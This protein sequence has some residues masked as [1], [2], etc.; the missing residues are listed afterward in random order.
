MARRPHLPPELL[1]C[2]SRPSPPFLA[3]HVRLPHSPCL[4]RPSVS[5]SLF[6][7]GQK[8]SDQ[9]LSLP[10]SLLSLSQLDLRAPFTFTPLASLRPRGVPQHR[11]IPLLS[12]S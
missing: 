8:T 12:A 3:H 10:P 9:T 7:R 5:P 4:S 1:P 2:S 11:E 6:S